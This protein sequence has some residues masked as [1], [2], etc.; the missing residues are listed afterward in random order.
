MKPLAKVRSV[1]TALQFTRWPARLGDRAPAS[2]VVPQARRFACRLAV[3]VRTD[4]WC[5]EI[6]LVAKWGWR[7]AVTV[8][9]VCI[10]FW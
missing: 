6:C 4:G 1:F 8:K 5:Q 2:A 9:V 10:P 3:V 7:Y